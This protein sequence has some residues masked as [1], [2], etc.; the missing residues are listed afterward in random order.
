M[1]INKDN[2]EIR[3]RRQNGT[4]FINTSFNCSKPEIFITN[5]VKDIPNIVKEIYK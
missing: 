1:S 5:D 4:Y 3:I 2:I